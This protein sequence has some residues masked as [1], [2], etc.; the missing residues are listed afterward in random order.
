MVIWE[1]DGNI[2]VYRECLWKKTLI[3]KNNNQAMCYYLQPEQCHPID[4]VN[5]LITSREMFYFFMILLELL[6]D[7]TTFCMLKSG[8][9]MWHKT[10]TKYLYCGN[11]KMHPQLRKFCNQPHIFAV[12]KSKWLFVVANCPT[13]MLKSCISVWSLIRQWNSS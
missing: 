11:F 1:A 13:E 9:S 5:L 3:E 6:L 8:F 7:T 2:P 10:S 12:D 4:L